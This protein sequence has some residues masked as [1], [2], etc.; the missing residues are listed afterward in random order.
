MKFFLPLLVWLIMATVI[1]FG[2]LMAVTG[3]GVW[4]LVLA[5]LGFILL[6]SKYGCLSAHD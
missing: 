2:I 6:F 1:I 4:L 5:A 3:K